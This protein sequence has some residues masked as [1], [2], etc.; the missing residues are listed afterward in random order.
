[1]E[2]KCPTRTA[3][4]RDHGTPRPHPPLAARRRRRRAQQGQLGVAGRGRHHRRRRTHHA[5]PLLPHPR[6]ARSAPSS[7]TP[8]TASPTP[9]PAPT[10]TRARCIDALQRVTDTVVPL[11]P[12]LSFLHAEPEVYNARDLIR[13][14]YEALEPVAQAIER[15]QADGSLRNDLPVKWVVDAYAGAILT[16]WDT[17]DEGRIWLAGRPTPGHDNHRARHRHAP[18]GRA[19]TRARVMPFVAL[20]GSTLLAGLANGVAMVALPWLVLDLTGRADA[21]GL[22]ALVSG[23][24]TLFASLFSGTLVDTLG[25][26]RTS[27]FS[28]L[29]S[30]VAVAAI[31]VVALTTGL[32]FTWVLVLAVLGAV[33]D[34]AGVTAR[35]SMLTGV[36]QATGMRLERVNG[37]HEAVWGLAFLVGPAVGAGLIATVGVESAFWAMAVAF[38]A[39]AVLLGLRPR[40]RGRTPPLRQPPLLLGRHHGRTQARLRRRPAAHRRAA[41]DRRCRDCLP[42]HRDRPSGHLPG[43]RRPG[44]PRRDRHGLQPRRRDRCACSTARSAT[45]RTPAAPSPSR[46]GVRRSPWS[47]SRSGPRPASWSRP[48]LP[49]ESCLGR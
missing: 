40:A 49:A 5:A 42:R 6:A 27:V 45:M 38:I 13:R 30:A 1:M 37:I 46:S 14:W 12:S 3:P 23:I 8:S 34:P 17:A 2:P 43:Q 39:S 31:P 18:D 15:G 25:R 4:R 36:S 16:A 24:P 22:V 26:R 33:F 9:S 41:L 7:R 44:R 21:A 48:G 29:M 32:T 11:G 35:E 20:E 10:P 47:S 19:M 28:D